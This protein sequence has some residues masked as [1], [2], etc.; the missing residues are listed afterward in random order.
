MPPPSK[1]FVVKSTMGRDVTIGV[2][3]GLALLGAVVWGIMGMGQGVTGHSVLA[4]KIVSKQFQPQ[5]EEQ[6]T[7]GRGGL[8]ERNVDGTY[9]MVVRTPDGHDYTVFVDKAAYQAHKDGDSFTFLP[10]PPKEQK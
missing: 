6:L 9:T 4:G 7:V 5:Q 3:A 8:D 2:I 1:P 10:P